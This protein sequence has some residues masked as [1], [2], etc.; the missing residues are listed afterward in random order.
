MDKEILNPLPELSWFMTVKEYAMLK[1]VSVQ[2][3][4]GKIKRSTLEVKRI[5]NFTLVREFSNN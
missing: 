3:V 2:S 5:G 1:K 4:Y